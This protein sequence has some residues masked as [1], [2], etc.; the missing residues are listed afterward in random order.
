MGSLG[1]VEGRSLATHLAAFPDPPATQG[2]SSGSAKVQGSGIFIGVLPLPQLPATPPPAPREGSGQSAGGTRSFSCPLLRSSWFPLL[3]SP[4]LRGQGGGLRQGALAAPGE[5]GAPWPG[6]RSS[7]VGEAG[8]VRA[9][10][11]GADRAHLAGT[12]LQHRSLTH[13]PC[14]VHQATY[15]RLSSL[16]SSLFPTWAAFSE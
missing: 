12:R 4:L 3:P 10:E 7:S 1:A 13:P 15:P 16:H 8:S 2:S 6:L 9:R 11:G 5:V 14:G